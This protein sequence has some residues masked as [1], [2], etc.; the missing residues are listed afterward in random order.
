MS[1]FPW[2]RRWFGEDYLQL[3]THRNEGEA[4]QAVA[5]LL[6]R[7]DLSP[8]AA[9]LDLACG[10]GRH[11]RALEARGFH[12]VG[13]DLSAPLLRRARRR[14]PGCRVLRGDM[15]R[16]PLRGGSLHLVTS[17]FTSFGYF[18]TEEEDR[19]VLA[20][21]R[22]VLRPDGHFLLDFLNAD[23][24]RASL[25]PEDTRE[26]AGKTVV[27]ARR[28]V[29]GGRRVEKEILIHAP[30]EPTPKRFRERV[31]LYGAGELETLLRAE[32]LEPRETMGD[33]QGGPPGPEAP[34]V[35]VLAGAG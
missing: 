9:I 3:Y 30:G 13:L 32:G 14:A 11:L 4:D 10:P 22:R 24:V 28:L 20:E 16:L 27:Q 15:R 35:I 31:R 17:F 12:P 21:I 1:E 6:D 34:R 8:D 25:T 29:E 33:Y 5:L 19:R 26:V 23:A 2:F 7:I 18:E